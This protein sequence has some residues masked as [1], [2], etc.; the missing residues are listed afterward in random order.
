VLYSLYTVVVLPRR[1]VTASCPPPVRDPERRAAS[2]RAASSAL[3]Q[4][5]LFRPQLPPTKFAL[6]PL[7]YSSLTSLPLSEPAHQSTMAA[8]TSVFGYVRFTDVHSDVCDT[9]Q[10][11]WLLDEGPARPRRAY[12]STAPFH[13]LSLIS[14]A[15]AVRSPRAPRA[16]SAPYVQLLPAGECGADARVC[17]S[18]R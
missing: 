7:L 12:S 17:R 9:R 1:C 11:W 13:S 18:R 6:A 14:F 3:C 10:R 15:P 16:S 5:C 2:G 4:H 8:L